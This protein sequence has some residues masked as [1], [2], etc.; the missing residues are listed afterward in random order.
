MSNISALPFVSGKPG[1]S[2]REFIAAGALTTALLSLSPPAAA[3]TSPEISS[4]EEA[5]HQERVFKA[6]HK[7]VYDALTIESQF[8]KIVQLSGV[9][10]ADAAALQK[11]TKLSPNEGGAFTLFGGYIYGR[12]VELVPNELIVQAWRVLGWPNGVYSI[13]R[14]ALVE[15]NGA[16]RVVF[17]HA[18]FP[19]G[20]AQHLAAGWQEHYWEPLRRF[21]G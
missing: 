1:L 18:A 3:D 5:I 16:T 14:F 6:D 4:S 13:A 11:P 12:Q 7:R 15:E 17:D 21:L 9:M 10:K 2:R 8:D 20:K 19:K